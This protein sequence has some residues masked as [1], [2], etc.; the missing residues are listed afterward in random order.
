RA[1]AALATAHEKGVIHRDLKPENIMVLFRQDDEGLDVVKICDFGIAKISDSQEL[2]GGRGLS[3]I[4]PPPSSSGSA[5]DSWSKRD[6]TNPPRR[7]ILIGPP[8]YMSPEQARGETLD[9]RADLY[10]M[11]LILYHMLPGRPP[12]LGDTALDVVI[13]H[14]SEAPAPP[15][16]F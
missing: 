8:E 4:A 2:E 14:I 1:L 13:K 16:T 7:G 11:G 5:A 6:R 12:F 15:R 3:S 10:S 9:A